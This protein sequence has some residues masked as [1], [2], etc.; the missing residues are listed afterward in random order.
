MR[1]GTQRQATLSA[2]FEDNPIRF[3]HRPPMAPRIPEVA[4]I[5]PPLGE[6]VAQTS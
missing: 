4:W 2:A 3:R 1:S 5:N 6:E